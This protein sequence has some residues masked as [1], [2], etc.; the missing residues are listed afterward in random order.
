MRG[1]RFICGEGG[2]AFGHPEWGLKFDSLHLQAAY[3]RLRFLFSISGSSELDR[4]FQTKNPQQ[5]LRVH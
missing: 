2:I 4:L 3:G 5:K 1:D